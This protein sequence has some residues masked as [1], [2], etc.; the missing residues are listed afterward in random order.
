MASDSPLPFEVSFD[1]LETGIDEY[2]KRVFTALESDFLVMPRGVGFVA[3][4]PF[5]EGY[6]AIHNATEG[7]KRMDVDRLFQATRI[8]RHRVHCRPRLRRAKERHEVVAAGYAR[9]GFHVVPD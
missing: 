9:I 7:F 5:T 4:D 8:R 1:R 3:F 6:R 2:V